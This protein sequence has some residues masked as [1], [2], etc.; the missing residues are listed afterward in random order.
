MDP[1]IKFNLNQSSTLRASGEIDTTVAESVRALFT[2]A[3]KMPIQW[4]IIT[5]NLKQNG[6]CETFLRTF[7]AH[8]GSLTNRKLC[9]VIR[10]DDR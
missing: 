10:V 1:N 2:K 8:E 6:K 7:R 4:T 5:R 3:L 9:G